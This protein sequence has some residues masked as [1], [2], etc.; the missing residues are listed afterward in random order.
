MKWNDKNLN[1]AKKEIDDSAKARED[2]KCI[3]K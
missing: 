2:P 3:D 1:H